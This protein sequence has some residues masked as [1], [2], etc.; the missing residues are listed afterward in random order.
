MSKTY[1]VKWTIT[2]QYEDT[3]EL[4]S[5]DIWDEARTEIENIGG[6]NMPVDYQWVVTTAVSYTH[7]TLPTTPYV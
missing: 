3:F 5:K 6:G 1:T 7:L 4:E 2:E